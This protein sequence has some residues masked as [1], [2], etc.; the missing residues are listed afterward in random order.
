MNTKKLV[1]YKEFFELMNPLWD[2]IKIDDSGSSL[3]GFKEFNE[4]DINQYEFLEFAKNDFKNGD[5]QGLIN[6]LSNSKRAIDC[7]VDKILLF[8]GI[9]SK[10]W[11]LRNF[12]SK[13]KL[14]QDIG[15]IT[16]RIVEKVI[17]TRNILEHEYKCPKKEEVE[18]A[19]DIATLFIESSNGR[20]NILNDLEIFYDEGLIE[21]LNNRN[22]IT[23]WGHSKKIFIETKITP[24]SKELYK[25]LLKLIIPNNEE[26]DVKKT[27]QPFFD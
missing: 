10:K 2:K 20:L 21:I 16:P 6:S 13:V 7:Q 22:F 3:V 25:P 8:F 12:P 9:N 27:L 11:N 18:N 19:I 24:Q 1:G 23:L 15:I 26:I 5:R 14:L 17:R 4:F